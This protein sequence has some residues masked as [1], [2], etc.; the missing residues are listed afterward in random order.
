MGATTPVPKSLL[1]AL[2][3]NY[4]DQF[5]S[6]LN[7]ETD[8]VQRGLKWAVWPVGSSE[9]LLNVV[10]RVPDAPER[11]TYRPFDLLRSYAEEPGQDT[12][13]VLSACWQ[14]AITMAAP[15]DLIAIALGAMA[16]GAGLLATAKRALAKALD[17]GDTDAAEWAALFLGELQ[18]QDGN[19][20]A[21]RELLTRAAGA[22]D[23]TIV[24]FANLDLGGLLTIT[25]ELERARELLEMALA[26]GNPLLVLPAQAILGGLLAHSGEPERAR[27]LL[28]AALASGNALVVPL[29]QA[30]LGGLLM[31]TGEPERARELLEAAAVSGNPTV[32]PQAH[33]LLGDLLASHEDRPRPEAAAD[34]IAGL[35]DWVE[36]WCAAAAGVQIDALERLAA[37]PFPGPHGSL[38]L[39]ERFA[40]AQ[41]ALAQWNWGL[42]RPVLRAAAAGLRAGGRTVPSSEVRAAVLILLSRIAV[43]L[44]EDPSA[45]LEA[46]RNLGADLADTAVVQ[47]W[48]ARQEGRP[49]GAAAHLADALNGGLSA[50]VLAEVVQQARESS[51]RGACPLLVKG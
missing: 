5:F 19:A 48:S 30:N 50:A 4:R 16:T 44:G 41:R 11:T 51:P 28:E 22:D 49:A 38:L 42:A 35:A 13:I 47:A 26:S 18:L 14:T 39:I 21:A 45:D 36:Q 34:V 46:A 32:V 24:E 17:S 29:A 33:F 12:A 1:R 8:D 20:E 15:S 31:R 2:A 27:E 6:Y 43:A 3:A 9:G 25:G 23:P 7:L 37:A 10:D 40:T